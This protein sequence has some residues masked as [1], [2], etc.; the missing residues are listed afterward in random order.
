MQV[1]W[2]LGC[3]QSDAS[4]VLVQPSP[5][6][7]GKGGLPSPVHRM[8]ISVSL[9]IADLLSWEEGTAS[10]SPLLGRMSDWG[11]ATD[12]TGTGCSRVVR[13]ADVFSDSKTKASGHVA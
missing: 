8:S 2:E 13:R 10:E 1:L 5:P 11:W 6:A 4:Q 12:P 9:E 7:G 3:F